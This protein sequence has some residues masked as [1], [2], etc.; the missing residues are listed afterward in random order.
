MQRFID[1]LDVVEIGVALGDGGK[2]LLDFLQ[3]FGG[4]QVGYP[5]WLLTTP[6]ENVEAE[7]AAVGFRK[8]VGSVE[9]G[10]VHDVAGCFDAAPLAAVFG[11]HLVPIGGEIRGLGGAVGAA[12]EFLFAVGQR[13]CK[14][15][16]G[17]CEE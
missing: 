6:D 15:G 5:R 2:P 8:V 10:P 16:S 3:L 14:G 13:G 7:K 9:V 4:R 1:D 12:E 11:G 17:G